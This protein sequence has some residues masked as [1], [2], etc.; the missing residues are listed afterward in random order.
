MNS[1][2]LTTSLLIATFAST[3]PEN[4]ME[5]KTVDKMHILDDTSSTEIYLPTFN[6]YGELAP[7]NYLDGRAEEDSLTVAH[8]FIVKRVA[9]C[10]VTFDL[11]QSVKRKNTK[12]NEYMIKHH[13]ENWKSE[14]EEKTGKTFSFPM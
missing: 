14:F 13:G 6:I 5:L 8:G 12:A 2:L 11:V 9:G 10:G 4:S 7:M 3:S 1:I